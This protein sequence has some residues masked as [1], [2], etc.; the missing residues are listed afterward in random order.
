MY[1]VL[2]IILA[3]LLMT[4]GVGMVPA[5]GKNV[6]ERL[7]VDEY[8]LSKRG[9]GVVLTFF[10]SMA[11]WY[12][13]SLFLGA[14]AEVYT[15]GIEWVFGFTSSA[16]AGLVFVFLGPKIRE[17]GE[18][19]K[20]VTQ[21]DMYEDRFNSR[22]LGTVASLIGVIF[23]LPY[24]TVQITGT[25]YIFETFT[26]GL[27]PYWAGA[28]FGVGICFL[29]IYFGGKRSVAWTDVF[30]GVVFLISIWSAVILI[31]MK[32]FGGLT[33][34]FAKAEAQVPE[35]LTLP[36][37]KGVTWTY[38]LSQIWVIGLGGY[39][40]PHLFLNMCSA[41]SAASVRKAGTLVI[42]ASLIAQVPVIF[43]ALAAA[44]LIPGLE[45][46]DTALLML[47]KQFAPVWVIGVL[48]AGG[49]AASLS[50]V[51]SLIHAEGVLIARDFY[52]KFTNK[53]AHDA[54]VVKMSQRIIGA[55]C[56]LVYI[57]AL[58]KPQFLWTI[59]A[60][61]Y[62]GVT[63]FFPVTIA[64]L[65]WK[66]ATREGALAAIIG[67]LS[68]ALFFT[69]G[70][71]KSPFGIVGPFWGMLVNTI[72]LVTVSLMTQTEENRKASERFYDFSF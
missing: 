16:L 59:L 31:F 25:A 68:A 72:L 49:I 8:F 1:I 33:Q 23:M 70:P 21:A 30:F 17:L 4:V 2:G 12:S 19:K 51:N 62:C 61:A 36:G 40:W 15:K 28:L 45:T 14:V 34:L 56:I 32:G 44:V 54:S 9:L 57:F 26:D 55:I 66:K 41:N 53:E 60:Q 37:P 18:K 48:G 43:G 39:M 27:I 3:F 50:T 67:G 69:L 46:P 5:L 47:V 22:T 64:T 7:T 35:L 52:S 13:S 29:F 65:Y 10:T 42:F 24:L 63:Q 58:T 71:V 6:Q 38:F 20:Y 11:T